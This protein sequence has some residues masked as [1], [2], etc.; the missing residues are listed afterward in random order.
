MAVDLEQVRRDLESL[1]TATVRI[2]RLGTVDPDTGETGRD[3]IYE[4]QGALLSTHGQ[5]LAVKIL[6]ADWLGAETA[7]Y[8]LLTPLGTP[9]AAAGDQVEV[10][11]GDEDRMWFADA[12]TQSSTLEA[13]RVT[14]L[15]EQSGAPAVGL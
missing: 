3:V 8:Q 13:A 9:S 15:D 10:L 7:W 4:G 5:L 2:S 14:R 6:G 1:M 11:G 12:P